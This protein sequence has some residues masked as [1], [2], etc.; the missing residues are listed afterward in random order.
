MIPPALT[1][2]NVLFPPRPSMIGVIRPPGVQSF[3]NRPANKLR[4]E[5]AASIMAFQPIFRSP[6]SQGGNLSQTLKLEDLTGTPVILVQGQAD[7]LLH[8]LF[9][10]LPAK[11]GDVVEA[12]EGLLA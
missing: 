12:G 5:G 3:Y 2:R 6:I 7:E 8:D 4:A 10:V 9:P 1:P 11:P